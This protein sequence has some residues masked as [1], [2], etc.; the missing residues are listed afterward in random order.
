MRFGDRTYE[1]IRRL[2][3]RGAL[4]VLPTG[5]TE[6][7]GPHLTVDFDTWFAETVCCAAA[8][9]LEA[10][11][12]LAVVVLPTCPFG[13]TPEHRD[14]GAGFV[15][16]PR[17]VHEQLVTAT[18]E[19]LADQGF[20]KTVVWQ[21]CGGHRLD[22]V[23]AQLSWPRQGS[24]QAF[25]PGQPY[26]DIWVRYGDPRDSGGHADSFTTSVALHLRP[27]QVRRDRIA[28]SG[29]RPVDWSDPNLNFADYSPNGVVGAPVYASADLGRTLWREVVGCVA[30]TFREIAEA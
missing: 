4:A 11:S 10:Q 18:L 17:D 7:R 1:E 22:G 3:D 15:D 27:D 28:D 21:G 6:Q 8:E 24:P 20:R 9:R 19:S 5:F 2:A 14:F 13:P 23:V 26:H 29:C 12:G 16:L 25:L 30:D